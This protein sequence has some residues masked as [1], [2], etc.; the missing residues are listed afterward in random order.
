VV[1]ETLEKRLEAQPVPG[2]S[3]SSS[4]SYNRA[5]LSRW[6]QTALDRGGRQSDIIQL[7]QRADREQEAHD[8]IV[9][10]FAKTINKL[11]GIAWR[12]V[13]QGRE[14]T[15]RKKQHSDT[16]SLLALEFFYR[17]DT[18]LY[19]KLENW[20]GE[21]CDYGMAIAALLQ[22]DEPARQRV[23]SDWERERI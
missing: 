3:A 10:G 18:A 7:L 13:E 4:D 17:P 22:R 20:H 11:P 2:D 1:S 8:W 9:E 6:L 21:D 14:V 12:L 5:K 23:N 19:R 16:A 15:T